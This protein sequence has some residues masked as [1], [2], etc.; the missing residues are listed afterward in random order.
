LIVLDLSKLIKDTENSSKNSE[1]ALPDIAKREAELYQRITE[2]V[3][4]GRLSVKDS[5]SLK[6][7]FYRIPRSRV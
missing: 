3:M 5:D 1:V 6:K 2:G 7:D 4:Q